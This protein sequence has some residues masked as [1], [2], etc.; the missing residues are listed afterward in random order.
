MSIGRTFEE[1]LQKAIR[2]TGMGAR[3]LSD[4]VRLLVLI[5]FPSKR[6]FASPRTGGSSPSTGPRRRLERRGGA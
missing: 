2:M 5:F 1:A 6:P 3:G 4:E